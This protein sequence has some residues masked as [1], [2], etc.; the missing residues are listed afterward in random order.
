NRS[1]ACQPNSRLLGWQADDLLTGASARTL[2]GQDGFQH[3]GTTAGA[4]W[5]AIRC[6]GLMGFLLREGA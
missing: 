2:A 1:S 3:K 4:W 6:A 5:G